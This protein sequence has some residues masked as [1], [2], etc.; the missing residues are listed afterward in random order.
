MQPGSAACGRRRRGTVLP[1]AGLPQATLEQRLAELQRRY[2]LT[3]EDLE[4][5]RSSETL[6]LET[7]N[8]MIE[9]AVGTF[10]L[11]LGLGLNLVV[12]GRDYVVPMAVEE[13]SVVA[14]VSFAAKI[15]REAGGFADS[16]EPRCWDRCRSPAMEPTIAAEDR[17]HKEQILALAN[18]FTPSMQRRGGG[19]RDIEVRLPPRPRAPGATLVVHLVIDTQRRW[20]QPHQHHMAEGVAPL[21]ERIT[22]GHVYP[23]S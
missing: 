10:A 13:P 7:A 16:D 5:L 3:A 11:P 15:V 4:L 22:G 9:N 21:I 8:Q 18:S 23:A 2:G 12:N 6:P 1:A 20:G 19:A 17:A 14:A